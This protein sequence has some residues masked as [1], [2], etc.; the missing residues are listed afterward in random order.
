MVEDVWRDRRAR[1][2]AESLMQGLGVTSPTRV[3]RAEARRLAAARPTAQGGRAPRRTGSFDYSGGWTVLLDTYGDDEHMGET[4]VRTTFRDAAQCRLTAGVCQSALELHA[5]FGCYHRCDYCFC[6]PFFHIACDLESLLDAL[7]Q[8]FAQYPHQQLFKFDNFT[9]T[10]VLEPEYGASELLVPYF[11]RTADRFLLLYT[12][13]DNVAHLLDLPHRGH[14]IMNWSL[15][16]TTQSRVIEVNAPDTFARI[17]AMRRCEE[18]GYTV[19]A[20]LSPIVPLVGW[21]QEFSRM[22]ETL[23]ASV[24]PDVVSVDVVGWCLPE[25]LAEATDVSRLDPAWRETLDVQM[26]VGNRNA[27][28]YLFPHALRESALRF[29]V[30]EIRRCSPQT[31]VSICNETPAMWA[32]MGDLLDMKPDH[33]VCCCGPDSVPGNPMLSRSKSAAH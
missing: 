19:R 22:A 20:R 32:A 30:S 26:G 18:A 17:D 21:Q 5:A 27:G 11:G 8:Y 23:F 28:K 24:H 4:I 1:S 9:D 33:Y 15:S 14:T 2:R 29:A 31:P 25:S 3:S 13:S 6:D 12:K 10:L 7:P 16:P